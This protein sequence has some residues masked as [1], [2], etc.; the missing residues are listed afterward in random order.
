MAHAH[1]A[2]RL[3]LRMKVMMELS[4]YER[5]SI[6]EYTEEPGGATSE[7]WTASE[8][9][10][11][12]PDNTHVEKGKAQKEK[13]GSRTH[14]P[15]GN[16]KGWKASRPLTTH[17]EGQWND[18]VSVSAASVEEKK[19][20]KRSSRRAASAEK[21]N[22]MMKSP[23]TLGNTKSRSGKYLRA[24]LEALQS[25]WLGN[26]I[27]PLGGQV[28]RAAMEEVSRRR[29]ANIFQNEWHSRMVECCLPL[30]ECVR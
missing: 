16:R 25:E 30:C 29:I 3:Q 1:G 13:E 27:P 20:R 21:V 15:L 12:S 9:S 6:G 23:S 26:I 4:W 24:D 2:V 11:G 7:A 8:D 5:A 22:A 10:T 18:A 28:K 14:D 17:S 19:T